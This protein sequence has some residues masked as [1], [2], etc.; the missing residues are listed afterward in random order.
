MKTSRRQFIWKKECEESLQTLKDYLSRAPLLVTPV[1]NEDLFLYL[2]VSDHATSL[3]LVRNE[4]IVHQPIY[5]SSKMMT[6]S[7]TRYLPME[8]LALALMSSKTSLL[9]YFQ[10][11]RIIVLTEYPLKV[12]LRKTDS[13]SRILKF[14]QDLANYDI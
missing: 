4:G 9:P 6:V 13:S 8:K 1:G 2:V 11:H 10:T 5:Y 14:S 12:V 7:Q 3:V